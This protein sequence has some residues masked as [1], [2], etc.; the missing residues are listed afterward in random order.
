MTVPSNAAAANRVVIPWV[1][2]VL[3]ILLAA[4]NVYW[5]NRSMAMLPATT[6]A[7]KQESGTEE[8]RQSVANLRQAVQDIQADQQKL[9]EQISNVQRK[10]A[11]EGGERKL[12]SDQLGALSARVDALA[13][14]NADTTAATPPAQ[15]SRRDRK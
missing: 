8:A 11:A 9:T 5:T 3:A 10:L 14:A 12:M 1:A 6:T 4:G 7:P 13:S 2:I 15:Q